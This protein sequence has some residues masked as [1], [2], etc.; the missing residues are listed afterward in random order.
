M[1]SRGHETLEHT[2]DMG[3]RGWGSSPEEAFEET[4]Q[5]MFDLIVDRRGASPREEYPLAATGRDLTELLIEFLNGLLS[6]SDIEEC[7][8][9]EVRIVWMGRGADGWKLESIAGGIPLD[10]CRG[11]LLGEVK[12]ATWYC[13][14]V[15]RCDDGRYMAECV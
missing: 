2:A 7:V 12:A 4:A 15:V 11:R 5:A 6:L 1:K 9:V 8:F 13:A 3:L 10:E 14:S